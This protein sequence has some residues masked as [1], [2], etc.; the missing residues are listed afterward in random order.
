MSNDKGRE[1]AADEASERTRREAALRALAQTAETAPA[2]AS[3]TA[4]APP[5]L[6]GAP[7]PR[8]SARRWIISAL[9]VLVVVVVVAIVVANIIGASRPHAASAKPVLRIVPASANLTCASQV[10]WSPDGKRIAALGN[11]NDCGGS[12]ADSQTGTIFI[13]DAASGKLLQQAHPDQAVFN[14]EAVGNWIAKNT[15]PSSAATSLMYWS[16]TWAPDGQSVLLYFN[17]MAA[18]PSA[19]GGSS[20]SG[21][22]RLGL[23]N[24]SLTK[25]WLGKYLGLQ[26][27]DYERWDLATGAVTQAPMPALATAYRWGA[28]GALIPSSAPRDG[29]VGSPD[30]GKLFTVWQAGS[31]SNPNLQS[32]PTAKPVTTYTET[33]WAADIRPISPDGRYYYTYF[34]AIVALT[35]PSTTFTLPGVSKAAPRDKALL[36]L[37]QKMTQ[38]SGGATPA[39][40]PLIAYRPDGHLLAEVAYNATNDPQ[41]VTPTTFT[42]SIYNTATGAL[43][44][45]LTP[46]FSGLQVGNAGQE[47]LA[48][49]PDGSRLML[50][51]NAYGALTIWGPGAL[52]A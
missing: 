42:V 2:T 13:Y 33:L 7:A 18:N 14:N 43:V 39:P 45:R 24:A 48:W 47:I 50:A 5:R 16:L 36:A 8:G 30:G 40:T 49:S 41:S 12:E 25:V 9:S 23:S 29:A 17:L 37:A 34:P 44:K 10:A 52:P 3:R 26:V 31:L 22:L 15:T 51:D 46:S 28:G 19:N 27:G 38:A 11:L 4:S 21:L 6:P 20:T 32:S 35:P 1:A